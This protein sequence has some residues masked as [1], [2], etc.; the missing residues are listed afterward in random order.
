MATALS[1]FLQQTTANTI[2]SN[3]TWEAMWVSGYQD[4]DAVLKHAVMY[5]KNFDLPGRT[6][7]YAGVS[8]KGVTFPN[9]VPTHMSFETEHTV[10]ITA[11]VNG[12]Y[13]RAFLA[14]MGKVMNPDI[15]GGSVLEG[16]RG[17]NDKA[18]VR[19]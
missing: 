1:E 11:D 9:I 12:Q 15:E 10:T 16:D 19:I 2:R 4:V 18:S 14:W 8:Y 7:E 17:V 6:V 5:G 3:N 13:R